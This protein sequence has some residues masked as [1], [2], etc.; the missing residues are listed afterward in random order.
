MRKLCLGVCCILSCIYINREGHYGV[1]GCNLFAVYA[2]FNEASTVFIDK[3][4]IFGDVFQMEEWRDSHSFPNCGTYG[5]E[6]FAAVSEFDYLFVC[7]DI[8]SEYFGATRWIVNNC[9]DDNGFTNPPFDNFFE[10]LEAY[11]QAREAYGDDDDAI[12]ENLDFLRFML[13]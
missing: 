3:E 9:G 2:N 5:W 7:M 10:R 8:N 13:F 4:M 12:L 6:C 1:Y 11:A